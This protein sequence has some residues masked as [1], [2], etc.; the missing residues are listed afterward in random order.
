M[1]G[2]DGALIAYLAINWSTLDRIGPLKCQLTCIMGMMV[3]FS[4][5][6]TISGSNSGIDVYGHLGGFVGGLFGGMLI[7]PP[8][9]PQ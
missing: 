1:L 4:L 3:F 8:I 9:N 5:F 6:Y 7:L 2:F